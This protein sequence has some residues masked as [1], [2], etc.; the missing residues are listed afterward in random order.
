MHKLSKILF[1]LL[2]PLVASATISAQKIY[3]MGDSNVGSKLYPDKVEQVIKT[4]HPGIQFKYSFK[5]G[6]R[7]A[8]F[9]SSPEFYNRI[10]TY[11][12]DILILNLGTND[13]YTEHFSVKNFNRD[14]EAF[15]TTITKK[16]PDIKIVF[17]TPYTVILKLKTGNKVNKNSRV[18]SDEILKFVKTH[19]N[20]YA[21]DV[22][23]T[24]GTTFIDSPKLNRDK[25]HLTVEGYNMLG[26]EV[27][28]GINKLA[29]LW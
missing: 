27:G 17:V 1:T 23:E 13:S 21:V 10:T 6:M 18:A 7:F 29:G 14:M 20:T 4:K 3:M 2:I 15:Y 9:K 19:P 28:D 22:N 25:I 12:P 26:K 24:F 16:L 5:N 8:H 11:K